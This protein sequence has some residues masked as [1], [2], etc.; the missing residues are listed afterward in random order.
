MEL[1]SS[2]LTSLK[3]LAGEIHW[4][5]YATA[6]F[7]WTSYSIF[8]SVLQYIF[9]YR[10]RASPADWKV[11][12]NKIQSLG[13]S[14]RWWHPL[15]SYWTSKA[16]GPYHALFASVNLFMSCCVGGFVTEV[17]MKVILNYILHNLLASS[18]SFGSRRKLNCYF[19]PYLLCCF[20]PISNFF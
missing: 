6:I 11:E 14:S 3:H 9:Y 7:L 10:K 4:Q 18:V 5:S 8:S 13:H 12:P 17:R 2:S 20:N 19:A 15:A 16:R 1:L